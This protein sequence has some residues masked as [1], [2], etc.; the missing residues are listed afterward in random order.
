MAGGCILKRSKIDEFKTFLNTVYKEKSKNI[1]YFISTQNLESL[2][3]FAKNEL[4][5][6]EPFGTNNVNP[7]FLIKENKIV[8]LKVIKDL[9]LQIVIVNKFNK[10]CLCYAFNVIGSKLGDYLMNKKN[11][12]DLIVQI[13]NKNIQKNTD[14]NLIIKDAIAW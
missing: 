3:K 10:S 4:K 12:I 6:I 8:K 14:F 7:F 5:K 1:K 9:H 13:N 11:K 2:L